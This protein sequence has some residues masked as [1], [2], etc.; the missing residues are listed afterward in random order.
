MTKKS[1]YRISRDNNRRKPTK[2]HTHKARIDPDK[3]NVYAY[4]EICG[5]AMGNIPVKKLIEL[6]KEKGLNIP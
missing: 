2:F 5:R 3:S 6:G 1:N 4:C